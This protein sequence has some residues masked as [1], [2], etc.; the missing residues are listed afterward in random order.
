MCARRLHRA[1]ALAG[2]RGLPHRRQVGLFPDLAAHCAWA[3]QRTGLPTLNE[4][5]NR[6]KSA[7]HPPCFSNSKWVRQVQ[8]AAKKEATLPVSWRSSTLAPP[9]RSLDHHQ[10][11]RTATEERNLGRRG[12]C[13]STST[14]STSS[15]AS[16]LRDFLGSPRS[17]FS[18]RALT[19]HRAPAL[20]IRQSPVCCRDGDRQARRLRKAA[21]V[22]PKTASLSN[23]SNRG[24]A[25]ARFGSE[26]IVEIPSS[27]APAAVPKANWYTL[28]I[29]SRKA[30][31]RS[32]WK[33]P[34]PSRSS[35]AALQW[36]KLHVCGF[37]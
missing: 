36:E 25:A 24:R 14:Q 22:A 7:G 18:G 4:Q 11:P 29:S 2:P 28:V 5:E 16:L 32:R 34:D 1:G 6:T 31:L 3:G 23:S 15:V 27:E 20:P 17:S 9:E 12:T 13:Q 30:A 21:V 33:Q 10:R 26:A 19:G 37:W 8:D 35:P